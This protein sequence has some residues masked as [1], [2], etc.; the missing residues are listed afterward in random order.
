MASTWGNNKCGANSWASDIV[1]ADTTGV[2]ITSGVGTVD[3]YSNQGWGRYLWGEEAWG[4]NGLPVTV[5]LSATVVSE[6]VCPIVTAIP[7][8]SVAIFI[9]P[10]LFVISESVP[11]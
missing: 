11:S 1:P 8:V 4:T 5:R 10:V 7:D 9:A 3:A 2:A 6:V